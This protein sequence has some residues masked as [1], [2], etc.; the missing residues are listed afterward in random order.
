M[1][2]GCRRSS[3]PKSFASASLVRFDVVEANI[4]LPLNGPCLIYYQFLAKSFTNPES[5]ILFS[6]T[7]LLIS[8]TAFV[9]APRIQCL[10]HVARWWY[11]QDLHITGQQR[12]IKEVF[13]LVSLAGR[14]TGKVSDTSIGNHFLL[15]F[16]VPHQNMDC[17]VQRESL[18]LFRCVHKIFDSIN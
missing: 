18:P 4:M 17:V 7:S 15:R 12:H 1:V 3:H 9:I 8:S 6:T 16:M 10:S 14:M 2:L 13:S 5:F 11:R